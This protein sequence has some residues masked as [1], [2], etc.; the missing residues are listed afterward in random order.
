MK[1][2]TEIKVKVVFC[3]QCNY[4]AESAGELCYKEKHSLK[5]SKALKK[6]FVCKNCKERTIAYGA[7]LPKHPCRKCGVSNYQKTSMYKEKEGPKIGGETLLVR[8][9][10]HAKFMNSLK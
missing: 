5:Y 2:I 6:F 8:G 1:T 7:P 9:E 4:V 10:E 3:K